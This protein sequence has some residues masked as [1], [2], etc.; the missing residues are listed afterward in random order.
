MSYTVLDLRM[1][2]RVQDLRSAGAPVRP[3]A[4]DLN[5]HRSMSYR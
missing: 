4:A 5:R 3:I 2:R 1:R